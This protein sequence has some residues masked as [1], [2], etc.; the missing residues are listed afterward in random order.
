MLKYRVKEVSKNIFVAIVP[1]R[2]QRAML[3]CR[4]QEFY[5]SPSSKFR[6]NSFSIWD[7]FSW[8][9]R[10]YKRGCF[11]YPSDFT[12]F[13]LPVNI[14]KKCYEMNKKETP[15]DYEMCSIIKKIFK[16]GQK[17]YLIGV[18]SIKNSTYKHEM[19]HALYYTNKKYKSD[20]NILINSISKSNFLKLKSNLKKIGYCNEVA[21]D[22]I[23]AYMA[24]E[25]NKTITNG[26]SNAI[27][28]HKKFKC[29]FDN[30]I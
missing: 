15:Y 17:Q 10:T 4:V 25:I 6:K 19:A 22:E 14:A 1:N 13:N 27:S 16:K 18:D 21:K 3:F 11:S 20:M 26:V 28:T 29:V 30:Y 8:Y 23:Q 7:Y 2:Y 12:G 24:T 5:E 9:A